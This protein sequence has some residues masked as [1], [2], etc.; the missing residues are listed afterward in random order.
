[1]SRINFLQRNI[2]GTR[3]KLSSRKCNKRV[4]PD[5]HTR[6]YGSIEKAQMITFINAIRHQSFRAAFPTDITGVMHLRQT[7][8]TLVASVA[9]SGS[10][11]PITRRASAGAIFR[12][13]IGRT[14]GATREWRRDVPRTRRGC[15]WLRY[16]IPESCSQL[17]S[18][19]SA[20]GSF[21]GLDT[22]LQARLDLGA[23]KRA[24]HTA[25]SDILTHRAK[26]QTAGV[27]IS[28]SA[29]R[30]VGSSRTVCQQRASITY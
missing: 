23:K 20:A 8:S 9:V 22:R 2:I 24:G 19:S 4:R 6:T 21:G 18:Y 26:F 14:Y 30:S 16:H 10:S 27:K 15:S 29:A 7:T 25:R 12:W 11:A 28:T 13:I 17:I 5:I 1:M 3:V